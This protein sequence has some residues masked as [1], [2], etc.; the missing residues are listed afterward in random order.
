MTQ[1]VELTVRLRASAARR[2]LVPV[3]AVLVVLAFAAQVARY[4]LSVPFKV[5]HLFDSDEKSNFPTG[6]KLLTL[7]LSSVLFA[8][9]AGVKRR[10]ADRWFRHWVG[11]SVAFA[12]LFVDE[13]A[14]LHQTLSNGIRHYHATSG[15][16]RYAWVLVFIPLTIAFGRVYLGFLGALP[17]PFRN[18]LLLA[19]A[20]FAGGSGGGELLKGAVSTRYGEQSLPFGLSAAVSDSLEMI[21]LAI[22]VVALL[23]LL[24]QLRAGVLLRFEGDRRPA[25][26]DRQAS[27]E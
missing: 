1:P 25:S 12:L 20:G 8:V 27:R 17:R 24:E 13:T 11:L 22:L 18:L 15:V 7:L 5:T 6:F 10:S 4:K 21:G 9:V 14:T 16:L 23:E 3:V 2:V 26:D 19:A